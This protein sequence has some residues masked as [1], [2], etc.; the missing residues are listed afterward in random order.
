MLLE[1]T[2]VLLKMLLKYCVLLKMLLK[3]YTSVAKNVTTNIS[4]H[5][6]NNCWNKCIKNVTKMLLKA[7]SE[8]TKKYSLI[9]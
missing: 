3:Y 8:V 5:F 4:K 2:C 9:N 7:F 6:V 1:I